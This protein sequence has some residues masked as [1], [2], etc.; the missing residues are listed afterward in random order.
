[1]NFLFRYPYSSFQ[2]EQ[3]LLPAPD[4]A[5][6]RIAQPLNSDNQ[7]FFDA[8]THPRGALKLFAPLA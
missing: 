5:R 4:I 1:M 8:G 2:C 7:I 3:P 6:I